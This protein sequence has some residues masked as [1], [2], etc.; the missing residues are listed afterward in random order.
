MKLPLLSISPQIKT[1]G[2]KTLTSLQQLQ[3][4]SA[5]SVSL[6]ELRFAL[7]SS[8]WS[9]ARESESTENWSKSGTEQ[10]SG[11]SEERRGEEM[12]RFLRARPMHHPQNSRAPSRPSHLPPLAFVLMWHRSAVHWVI[13]LHRHPGPAAASQSCAGWFA[14]GD[15]VLDTSIQLFSTAVQNT[16]GQWFHPLRASSLALLLSSNTHSYVVGTEKEGV[17]QAF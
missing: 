14:H 8:N 13:S 7:S 17:S 5:L 10:P 11:R 15:R 12:E 4:L 16:A 1:C 3:Q 6:F 2:D 9:C